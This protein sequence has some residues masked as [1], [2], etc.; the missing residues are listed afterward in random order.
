MNKITKIGL[1]ISIIGFLLLIIMFV[2]NLE[3]WYRYIIPFLFVL[4]GLFI[5]AHEID[6]CDSNWFELKL[7]SL[8]TTV[9][10]LDISFGLAQLAK[11]FNKDNLTTILI[12]LGIILAVIALFWANKLISKRIKKFGMI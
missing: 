1:T 7:L 6:D 8:I 3:G 2:V 9:I 5:L 10:L 11:L 4:E 12:G